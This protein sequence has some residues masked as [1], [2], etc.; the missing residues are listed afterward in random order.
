MKEFSLETNRKGARRRTRLA[1]LVAGGALV[2]TGML[3]ACGYPVTTAA[4]APTPYVGVCVDP[5]TGFRVA[6]TFCGGADPYTGAALVAGYLWDYYPPS[7]TGVIAAYGRPVV[8]VTIIHTVPATTS[9]HVVVIDRGASPSGGSVTS[10]RAAA[11]AS[12]N[13]VTEKP[14]TSTRSGATTSGSPA[15]PT[16]ASTGSSGA[17]ATAAPTRNP[18]ITRGGFGVP[19]RTR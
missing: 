9:T 7:Y 1:G 10:V 12:H 3:A 2:A 11:A 8:G 15:R 16:T 13:Q 6:D 5:H 18:S 19:R 17:K 4:P 14:P